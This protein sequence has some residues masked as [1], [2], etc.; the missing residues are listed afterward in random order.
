MDVE[1]PVL[2]RFADLLVD[3]LKAVAGAQR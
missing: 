2:G 1:D 3:V